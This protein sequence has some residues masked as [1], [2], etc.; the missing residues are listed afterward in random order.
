[1]TTDRRHALYGLVLA[2]GLSRRMGQDKALLDNDGRTQLDVA[3]SLIGAVTD[4]Q[5]VSAR[6]AQ[7]GD[8]GRARYPLIVDRYENLGPVAG[9][10]SAMDTHDD[11]DWLVLAC[12]LPNLDRPTLEFLVAHR[13]TTKPFVAYRSAHDGLPE[14]L[15]AIYRRGGDALIRNF[16]A[17]GVVCPRKILIRSDTLLLEQPNPRALDNVN[18]PE[19]L[20]A[21]RLRAVR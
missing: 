13:H 17:D 7:S 6:S 9:I 8:P 16:V 5:F 14:P 11:V 10:L 20:A 15:C 3:V 12:D 4:K 18:T 2:G 21:S 1:M 19:D